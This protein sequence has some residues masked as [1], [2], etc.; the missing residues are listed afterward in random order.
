MV[1]TLVTSSPKKRKKLPN[2]YAITKNSSP[3]SWNQSNID[4][5]LT[6]P[7]HLLEANLTTLCKCS[8]SQYQVEN[9]TISGSLQPH[10]LS[11]STVAGTDWLSTVVVVIVVVGFCLE[12]KISPGL[13]FFQSIFSRFLLTRFLVFQKAREQLPTGKP[14]RRPTTAG[15]NIVP[16]RLR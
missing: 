7:I 4:W 5:K 9:L 14:Q 11:A 1:T 10:G 16:F 13:L 2:L 15:K 12:M 6:R 3:E 8:R